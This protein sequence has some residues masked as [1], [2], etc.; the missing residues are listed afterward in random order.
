MA[1]EVPAFPPFLFICSIR[2]TWVE[3]FSET[4]DMCTG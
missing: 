3:E 2:F 1:G 4:T